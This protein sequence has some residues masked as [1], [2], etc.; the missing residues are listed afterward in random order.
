MALPFSK[1]VPISAVVQSPAFTVEKKH[2]LLAMTSDLISTDT[3]YLVYSGASALTNFR[4]DFGTQIPEYTVAS[5][6]FGFLSKTGTAPEKLI[7]A[8]WYKTAAAPFIVG[9]NEIDTVPQLK[10]VTNGSFTLNLDGAS[11]DVV[12]DLSTATS[13]TDIATLMQTAIRANATGGD[14]FT[15]ATVT[16]NTTRNAFV[17]ASG[18][19]G[20]T[21][22]IGEVSAGTTGTDLS[23]PL[24]LTTA[25]L[26]QGANAETF[27]EFC[28]RIYNANSG[29]Y[30]IT[31]IETLT[32]EEMQA[33]IAW[34]Q[35]SDGGQT[36]NTMV[37]LVFNITDKATAKALQS[38]SAELSYTGYVVCF[39]PNIEYVNAL[40]CAIAASID[41]NAVNGAVNF[42]FQPA[43]GYT[44]ITKLGDVLNY[45]QGQTNLSVA[46]ELDDLCISYVYSVG[47]GEQQQVLYGMGLMQGAF[48]TED[49]QVNESALE[50]DLQ[51]AV[52]NGFVSLNK[53]KLQ[54]DDAREFISTIITP[55]FERFKTNGSI[56]QN[57]KLSDTDKNS[58]YMITGVDSA[59]ECVEN[60]GY[61]FQVL[62]LTD[63][64]IKLRRVRIVVCYLAGG[65]INQLR[66]TNNIYGA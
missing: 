29:G 8:R 60:N 23:A 36:R 40:D 47:F 18:A 19:T 4:A 28:D 39:D 66:I 11:F 7:V 16:Y 17:I 53:L 49:I 6:Y 34:L 46:N 32:A 14:A 35:G 61:Y 51:T 24:G 3:P 2:M 65:V 59:A 9:S 52:M 55:T 12:L 25:T 64:D 41:F 63:E 1:F 44:P 43:V 30:S 50:V 57:G 42:N 20:T 5:K 26:S 58:I 45:Q 48:G 15:G 13:Y 21:A 22:T 54:G 27:T 56:A 31:T 33:A 37:R 10:S 62:D 38:T